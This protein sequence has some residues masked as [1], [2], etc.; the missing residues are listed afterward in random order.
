M[1][2]AGSEGVVWCVCVCECTGL[3]V[4]EDSAIRVGDVKGAMHELSGGGVVHL[5]L[6]A[7]WS[8]DTVE[9]EL[10]LVPRDGFSV[11]RPHFVMLDAKQLIFTRVCVAG[12]WSESTERPHLE[13]G[14]GAF[15]RD[16]VQR[17]GGVKDRV[18]VLQNN[19]KTV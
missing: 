1:W 11:R 4:A 13:P 16:T 6:C 15:S 10:Q 12:E 17:G 9:L 19:R 14:G 7:V 2:V 3:S 5:G 18:V 8:E